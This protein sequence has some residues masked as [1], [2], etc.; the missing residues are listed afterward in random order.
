MTGLPKPSTTLKLTTGGLA[1]VTPVTVTVGSRSAHAAAFAAMASAFVSVLLPTDVAPAPPA[2]LAPPA[3]PV[4]PAGPLAPVAPAGPA[5]PAGPAA[6]SLPPPPQA[7]N[8]A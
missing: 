1:I 7:A 4:A 6:P 5:G 2:P 3:G 8:V